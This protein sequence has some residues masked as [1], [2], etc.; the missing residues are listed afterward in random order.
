MEITKERI[1]IDKYQTGWVLTIKDKNK[2]II[3]EFQTPC[4]IQYKHRLFELH[5]DFLIEH[6]PSEVYTYTND[7]FKRILPLVLEYGTLL[8]K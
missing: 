5:G 8:P 6:K 1:K 2:T 3:S 4:F 7:E